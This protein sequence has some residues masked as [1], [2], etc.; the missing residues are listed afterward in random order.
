MNDTTHPLPKQ[1]KHKQ[2]VQWMQKKWPEA[3]TD[4]P[5]PLA[6]NSHKAI[7]AA[8]ITDGIPIRTI[9]RAITNW[10]KT[11]KYLE[12]VACSEYRINLDG[13]QAEPIQAKHQEY[14]R[15]KI[16]MY[17]E[18]EKQ[19]RI[20]NNQAKSEDPVNTIQ[21]D[22]VSIPPETTKRPKLTLKRKNST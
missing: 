11:K 3:F 19:Q 17:K 9:K 21:D 4:P 10:C 2:I 6:I 20:K 8:A 1:Y 22:Q 7:L 18:E 13:S 15:K 5:R 16:E 14:A 12:T